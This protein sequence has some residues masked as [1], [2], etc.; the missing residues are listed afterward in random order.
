MNKFEHGLLYYLSAEQLRKIQSLKI[1]IGGAGGLGSNAVLALVRCGFK[2]FE[3]LDKDTVEPSNLNRQQYNIADIEEV[4][5]KALKARLLKINPDLNIAVHQET[6]TLKNA[7]Q[8]FVGY[9]VVVEAF[10]VIESKSAFVDFYHDRASLVVSGSGMAG[11]DMSIPMEVK[12][13]GNVF[14][15]GDNKS[16]TSESSPPFAPR[17]FQCAAMMAGIVFDWAMSGQTNS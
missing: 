3:I 10:D 5:V 8:F 1:G 6:W 16:E 14:I 15:V 2:T 12:Q 11:T 17:V 13:L 4:K 9:D 7:E